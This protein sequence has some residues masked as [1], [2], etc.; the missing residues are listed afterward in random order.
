MIK[1]VLPLIFLIFI[2]CKESDTNH[3][4]RHALNAHVDDEKNLLT[5]SYWKD[6]IYEIRIENLA[7]EKIIFSEKIKD[8]CFTRPRIKN[9]QVYFPESNDSFICVNYKTGEVLWKLKTQGRVRTFEFLNNQIILLSIDLYGL[10]AVNSFNGE[11]L[12]SLPLHSGKD[13]T[14]DSAPSPIVSDKNNFYVADFNCKMISAYKISS[15]DAIWSL[16]KKSGISN[17]TVAGKYLF[18]GNALSDLSAGIMLLDA[19]TGK[20]IFH[21]KTTFNIFFDPVFHN[22]K[23]Y[24]LN[25][26]S[27]LQEFDIF[28]KT[29]KSLF[30]NEDPH[31]GC[32]QMFKLKADLYVQDCNYMIQ[33]LDLKRFTITKVFQAPKGL[34][35]VYEINQKVKFIF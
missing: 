5:Y 17:F 30:Y 16:A 23:I 26:D 33:K 20:I 2:T 3:D 9:S 24:Y 4:Q 25:G 35:G 34:L 14:V 27:R 6:D 15:G 8:K 13:C 21:Q 10:V 18:L 31:F 7:S 1:Y 11:I 22:N 19:E 12:Y 32:G 29:V 28:E